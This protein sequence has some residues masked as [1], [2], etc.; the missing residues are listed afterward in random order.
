MNSHARFTYIKCGKF[1]KVMKSCK[2]ATAIMLAICVIYT[3]FI[4]GLKKSRR[5]RGAI[6]FETQES[7]FVFNAQRK[8][9]NIVP[10]VRKR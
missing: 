2:R 9:E 5:S 8:I 1:C 10:L 3:I 6:E 4:G 7:K